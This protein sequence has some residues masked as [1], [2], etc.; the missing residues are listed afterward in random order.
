MRYL[1]FILSI[2]FLF[3]EFFFA[4]NVFA[5][6]IDVNSFYELMNSALANDDVY[7]FT[8]NMDST[9]SIGNH[10]YDYN[11]NF[12]GNNYYI[13]GNNTFSGFILS[14]DNSFSEVVIQHC[15]GQAY[16]ESNFAGAIFN[17]G[18]HTDI[19]DS[20]FVENFVN[21]GD[22]NFGIAGAVYNLYGGSINIENSNFE[23][24]YTYGA[25]SY[26]G[27]LSNGYNDNGTAQMNIFNTTFADNYSAGVVFVQGGAVYNNGNIVI[28]SST[29]DSNY[30]EAAP[31]REAAA[32]FTYGGAIFNNGQ[33]LIENSQFTQNYTKGSKNSIAF[34]GVIYNDKTLQIDNSNF[35][36]N[37]IQSSKYG[38]GAVIYNTQNATIDISNSLFENN[39]IDSN[40]EYG[41]GGAIYNSGVINF[42]NTTFKNNYD[43]NQANDIYNNS[44][45]TL[46]F[47][48]SGE[49]T[50]LS[51]I[52]GSGDINKNGSGALNLGGQNSD[53]SGDFF[54]NAGTLNLLADSTYFS[55]Q[56]STFSN[57]VNFNM[58]N[59]QIN[60]INF[61][62]LTLNG[63]TNV[64]A[65]VDFSNNTM[66]RI[67]ANSLN[68]SG[69][70]FV[71][72]LH[73]RGVP[74]AQ[75]ILIPFADS[76]LKDSVKYDNST[77]A[78]PIYD[79]NVSYDASSGDFQFVR[80][81]FDSA[82]L[83]SEVATQLAGYLVQVDT[84]KNIFSNL[85]M[86]MLTPYNTVD[87]FSMLNK[88]AFVD[89]KFGAD[90]LV[91]PEQRGGVW[92][93]PFSSFETVGLKNGPN[94]SNVMYGSIVAAES[95]LLQLKKNWYSLYGVY[96]VYNGSHQAYSG[97][98]IYN[99]GGLVG[100]EGAFY[101]GN[102][103]TLW[104]ANVGANSAE[105]STKFGRD[106]FA[107]L[108]TGLA[109]MTGYNFQT[110]GRKFIIQ[111]SIITSYSFVN[112]FSY[113]SMAG[114]DIETKP[115]NA[116]QIEPRLKLIGN[117]KKYFQPYATVSVVWNIIDK[118]EFEAND[119][120]LPD[121]S[122]KPF[123]QYGLGIQKRYGDRLTGFFE[124][125]IRN[126]G[127]SGVALLLG[128]RFSI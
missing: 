96:A 15:K 84:Y 11:I 75:K 40:I 36:E 12:D 66:D 98:S 60:D 44:T 55:A 123:V 16:S 5:N 34:G 31:D 43:R 10:F 59:G 2:L 27:A 25:G 83:A 105:A 57:D 17:S 107:M 82:V 65:D 46:N 97:N 114:V 63:K 21:S 121:L 81:G 116:I 92:F 109:Q 77:L 71:T 35:I 113:T 67:N 48:G 56:N 108:S 7:N 73:L 26:G 1:K 106:N 28:S 61:G 3:L 104:T 94:V 52:S 102:L 62:N 41:D 78:T 53:F 100:I 74:E 33:M 8:A 89:G 91:I 58:V 30:V 23:R 115:L 19:M 76:V 18:G 9:S 29:F 124:T 68:G 79:Y 128:F 42:E 87:K 111:P 39:K 93:K 72:G 85:D 119:V 37:S 32:P 20:D 126:G 6:T 117:F 47:N 24:N 122:V 22:Q 127:R 90:Q 64:F 51:G 103:F 69:E 4:D 86:V 50:I 70:I 54:F 45:G 125:L 120:H 118:A 95:P 110:L 99:N 101:K 49:N 38:D 80:G 13:D 112:T 14:R 88:I